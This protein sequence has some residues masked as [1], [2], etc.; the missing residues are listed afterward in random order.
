MF[1]YFTDS[2]DLTKV[3][4]SFDPSTGE[5]TVWTTA[6]DINKAPYSDGNLSLLNSFVGQSIVG[7]RPGDRH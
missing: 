6:D 5:I 1:T 2:T 3:V 7:G 4:K